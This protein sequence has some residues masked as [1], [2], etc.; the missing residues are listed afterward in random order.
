MRGLTNSF[1]T[2]MGEIQI[3]VNGGDKEEKGKKVSKHG[4][5]EMSVGRG[6]R[7]G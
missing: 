6:D 1:K 2:M 5:G 7:R 3:G 4:L